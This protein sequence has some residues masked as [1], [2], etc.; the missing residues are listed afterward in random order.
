MYSTYTKHG[1]KLRF[2]VACFA[3][4]KPPDFDNLNP[5]LSAWK[6]FRQAH[7]DAYGLAQRVGFI[8]LSCTEVIVELVETQGFS[9]P[10]PC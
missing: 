7:C 4:L 1:H 3:G 2:S 9:P 6:P 8:R 10:N 5:R